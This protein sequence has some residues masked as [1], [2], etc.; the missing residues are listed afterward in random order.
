MYRKWQ[1]KSTAQIWYLNKIHEME[2]KIWVC[3]IMQKNIC[4]SKNYIFT[5]QRLSKQGMWKTTKPKQYT[6]CKLFFW[7]GK[8]ILRIQL[9]TSFSDC[10]CLIKFPRKSWT[11]T[12]FQN[13]KFINIWL[14]I[15]RKTFIMMFAYVA[16][17]SYL[18]M[19]CDP[20]F[21]VTPCLTNTQ[22]SAV[23]VRNKIRR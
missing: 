2:W 23:L 20:C 13:R 4:C 18:R 12:T 7:I 11:K 3:N 8:I 14:S 21:Y 10:K 17:T 19:F 16:V 5:I 9:W 22:C 15:S 6:L 1:I